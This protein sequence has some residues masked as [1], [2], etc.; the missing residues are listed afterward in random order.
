MRIKTLP[1]EVPQ[2]DG[3][4][5]HQIFPDDAPVDWNEEPRAV[6]QTGLSIRH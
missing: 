5:C 6:R 2:G 1:M 3:D 4:P